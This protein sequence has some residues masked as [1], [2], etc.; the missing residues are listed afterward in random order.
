[1]R[2]VGNAV[3]LGVISSKFGEQLSGASP[4][5]GEAL[6]FV[7]KAFAGLSG[8][9]D[10]FVWEQAREQFVDVLARLAN[11]SQTQVSTTGQT[12]AELNAFVSQYVEAHGSS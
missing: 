11:K 10:T 4:K 6:Q 1:M 3:A 2:L 5:L 7:L 8:H 9:Q 12:Y